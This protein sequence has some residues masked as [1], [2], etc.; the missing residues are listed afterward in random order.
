M[1]T[2]VPAPPSCCPAG[3]IPVVD[4]DV[5]M[6]VV[7]WLPVP[8]PVWLAV[9]VD[10]WLVVPVAV[11][12][13]VPAI[14][15][16]PVP[17]LVTLAVPVSVPASTW[18]L[19]SVPVLMTVLA[20]MPASGIPPWKESKSREQEATDITTNK[21]EMKDFMIKTSRKERAQFPCCWTD[22]SKTRFL[23]WQPTPPPAPTA[24]WSW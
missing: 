7:V 3:Q 22:P 4:V 19:V 12:L 11:W 23:W 16:L 2:H 15:W 14:V 18:L 24:R 17:V 1:V 10:V 20:S 21:K 13:A 5:D 6:D 8:V 9:P